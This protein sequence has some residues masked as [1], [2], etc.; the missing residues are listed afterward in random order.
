[1]PETTSMTDRVLDALVESG[2]ITSEQRTSATATSGD[3]SNIGTVL[4]E[5]GLVSAEDIAGVLEDELGIPRV[6]LS[7]YAPDE[8]A[9]GIVPASVARARR[10]LPLFE[11]EGM[12]TVAVG[13]P[14]D[15]FVL[16]AIAGELGVEVEPVITD[17]SSVRSALVQYYG[18]DEAKVAVGAE[19][20]AP[21]PSAAQAAAG[22]SV[23]PSPASAAVPHAEVSVDLDVLAVADVTKVTLLVTDILE[24]AAS[25]GATQIHLLPYKDDFFLTARVAGR[26]E[27]LG[28]APL[29]MQGALVEGFKS[30]AR[31]TAVPPPLPAIGRTRARLADRDLALTVSTV[32]TI[33]GQR[34][35]ITLAPQRLKPPG[36]PQL[37]MNEA[38]TKALHA[39]TE[40]GR[41]VLLVCAPVAGGRSSTYYALVD[42]AADAGKT[43]YSVERAVD[44]ELPAVAQVLVTPGSSVRASAYLAAGMR[45]DTDV[46]A[47]DGLETAEEIHLAV[48]A[49]G[50][51]KLVIA[52]FTAAEIV[53]GI[54]RMLALGVE[55]HGLAAALTMAVAQRLVR[56]NCGKCATEQRSPLVASIPGGTADMPVK[57]GAGCPSCAN[58]GF[59]GM[60]GV[61]EVLPFSEPLRAR[62]AKGAGAGE[63]TAAAAA[64]GMRPL[65]VSGLAK[66]KTGVVGPDELN[67]VL[68]FAE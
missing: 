59:M 61:F 18:E 63:L 39:M 53:S 44:Y 23:A 9:L 35:V 6:D 32:T 46:I 7:S 1:M 25:R 27:K 42:H 19:S 2:L 16:D 3:S 57:V 12:L 29:S 31:L 62:I 68:R 34:V 55:P 28:S 65:S 43:V 10:I 20:A 47:I 49:A 17:P 30:F 40:R 66:L 36:L 54:V 13:D 41:G 60:T 58:T 45:Q 37:G 8:S 38:E 21:P 15:V 52:T 50:L 5:R 22:L 51:G 64:A 67:R 11:I 14:L 33:A 56:T 48:E 24:L 4:V 26:L